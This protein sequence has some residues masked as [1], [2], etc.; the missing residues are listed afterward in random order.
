M[1]LLLTLIFV[2]TQVSGSA[3][4]PSGCASA[5]ESASTDTLC[6][7]DGETPAQC[8]PLEYLS[9]MAEV[10]TKCM[11]SGECPS[12]CASAISSASDSI[13]PDPNGGDNQE[14]QLPAP[15]GE[16]DIISCQD[17]VI[18]KCNPV[19]GACPDHDCGDSCD[20]TPE[21]CESLQT[22]LNG[23]ASTCSQCMIDAFN[24][25]LNCEESNSGTANTETNDNTE[26]VPNTENEGTDGD[27][28][29]QGDDG[30]A[31]NNDSSSSSIAVLIAIAAALFAF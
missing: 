10:M 25:I 29:D 11:G 24:E 15:C 12:E 16:F 22:M 27:A 9:C 31:N 6:G 23:C 13:C 1:I 4:C 21:S 19:V 14:L 26:T 30:G 3:G 28:G 20:G 7:E 17:E 18:E 2:A 5:I 8:D